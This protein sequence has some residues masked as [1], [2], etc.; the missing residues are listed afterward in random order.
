MDEDFGASCSFLQIMSDHVG[1][2]LLSTF[3]VLLSHIIRA[4]GY[5]VSTAG[6]LIISLRLFSLANLLE[7][8]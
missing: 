7:R 6:T 1:N 4:K 3:S 5:H 2:V 8:S